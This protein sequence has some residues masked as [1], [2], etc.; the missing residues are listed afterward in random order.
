MQI[1][2]ITNR[3]RFCAAF[4]LIELL[5]VITIIG[6]LAAIL[7]PVVGKARRSARSAQCASNLH[8]IG[9][10]YLSYIND[11]ANRSGALPVFNN[12]DPRMFYAWGGAPTGL[13]MIIEAGHLPAIPESKKYS[14]E[15]KDRLIYVCPDLQPMSSYTGGGDQ[16]TYGGDRRNGNI[17]KPSG[18]TEYTVTGRKTINDIPA[19]SK[20]I[21]LICHSPTAAHEARPR[22]MFLDGHV[23]SLTP[24]QTIAGWGTWKYFKF[25]IIEEAAT[26]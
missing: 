11:P 6:I 26:K 20:R 1:P 18:S 15:Y 19:P 9:I 4:S 22:V 5:T 23:G 7:I 24:A 21:Q 25:D 16:I 14:R 10:G 17:A 8:Q 3:I 12:T 13:A 2:T